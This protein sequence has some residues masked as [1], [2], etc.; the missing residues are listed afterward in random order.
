M[1]F[2][3]MKP[4]TYEWAF[5]TAGFTHFEWCKFSLYDTEATAEDRETYKD[6]MDYPVDVGILAW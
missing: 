1:Q 6:L 2:F 4:E 5:K 3:Y